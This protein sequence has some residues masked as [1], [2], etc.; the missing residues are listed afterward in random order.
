M[1][2]FRGETI[3][4]ALLFTVS[5]ILG[6]VSAPCKQVFAQEE[7]GNHYPVVM[8]HGLFGWGNNE[9]AGI[10]YWGGAES[11]SQKLNDNGY[12]VYTPSV[13]PISSN[14]DRACELYAYMKGG[15][16]DYGEAHAKK[17][18]HARYGR[19]YTGVYPQFGTTDENGIIQKV[20]LIGH[21]M[22][23]QTIRVLAQLLETGSP[24]EIA[25][26]TDG[27][28]SP[29]FAGGKSWIA[30]IST[31]A[32]PHNGSQEAYSQNKIE[33]FAHQIFAA[34]AAITGTE[35]SA[36]NYNLDLKMDQWGLKRTDSESYFSYYNRVMNSNLWKNTKDISLWDLTPEGAKELNEK[37]P[38]MKDVYYFSLACSDTHED[39]LTHYQVPNLNMHPILWKSSIFMGMY[40]NRTP[41]EVTIDNTW[42]ENDGVV[43]VN[44]AIYPTLNSTDQMVDYNG[45]PQLGVWNYLGKLN[46]I[47]HLE[48][49]TMENNRS[50]LEGQFFDL[51][52][53]LKNLPE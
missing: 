51:L 47:D 19:T 9:V 12:T 21:S 11:L 17:Y 33:P 5:T 52:Q 43:S 2:K 1:K 14:W 3:I 46:N 39:I 40:T 18:G 31:I 32:T 7:T 44:S 23:G 15:T 13:G 20:H 16:V 26:T 42:W 25:A 24:E 29:L 38:A 41:G 45:T 35:I 22:G 28:L 6:L 34:L 37:V 8:V 30:S 48:V 49:V 27:S 36:G 50:L 4:I 53:I 10:N